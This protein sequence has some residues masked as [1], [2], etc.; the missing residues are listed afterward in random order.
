M[1]L[2]PFRTALVLGG[3]GARGLAHLGVLTTLERAGLRPDMI[4]G[5]SFGAIVG[6]SYALRPEASA[7]SAQFLQM[8]SEE[9]VA[10][11]EKQFD[12]FQPDTEDRGF[13]GR[14]SAAIGAARKLL[15]WNRS[16][17]R[18]SL[19]ESVLIA[20]VIESLVGNA[21]FEDSAIPFFAVAFDLNRNSDVIIGQG[22]VAIALRA[23]CA[24]PGIF[25]P[26][27][28]GGRLLV[29]GA[30]FQELPVYAARR[31]GADFVVAVDVGTDVEPRPPASSAEVLQR[32]LSVRGEHFRAESR[33]LSD[34]VVRPAVSGVRWSEFSRAQECLD[35]GLAATRDLLPAIEGGMRR[36][37]RRTFLRRL[38]S[39]P[40]T[41]EVA[42]A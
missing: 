31:L 40:S 36:A 2:R 23:S 29:D 26:V 42:R 13:M 5:T 33:A 27:A 11:I 7:L 14:V 28:V 19:V 37:R 41:I 22:D 15:L 3:G 32:V 35:A 34:A 18:L 39:T 17:M 20:E 10:G 6:A 30:V 25:E 24:I 12:L 16:V 4:V 38:T 9:R 1:R 21:Q 8:V